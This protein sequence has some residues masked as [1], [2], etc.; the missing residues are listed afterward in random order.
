MNQHMYTHSTLQTIQEAQNIAIKHNHTTL[1]PEHIMHALL[2]DQEGLVPTILH[3]NTIDIPNLQSKTQSLLKNLPQAT[4]SPTQISLSRESQNVLQQ[5]E[6]NID[7]FWDKY[8]T[9]EHVCIALITLVPS[10][11]ELFQECNIDRKKLID[12]IQFVRQW[13]T[14]HTA[15]SDIILDALGKY[16]KDITSLAE[17]GK[18]DPIIGRHTE[19]RRTM[20]ILSRR[21]K[22]N[23]V[24]VGDPW[25]WKTAIVEG[26]A[27][28]INKKEVPD[29]LQN[30][31]LI[32]LDLSSMLA[33]AKYRWDFEERLKAVLH[34]V[35][36][37]NDRI[38]LF[39]DEL[40]TIVWAWKTEWSADMGN[41]LKP[42]LARGHIRVIGATTI[43]EYRQ[44]I[45][46]DAALE[47]R[48]QPVMVTEPTREEAITILRGIKDRYETHH[49][50]RIT[51]EAVVAAVDL[52]IKYIN[53]RRLPDKAIDLIDEAWAS[54]KINI[55]SLPEHLQNIEK[56][57]KELQ[58]EKEAIKR[59]AW[60]KNTDRI[61]TIEKNIAE[62]HEQY[63]INKTKREKDK[64]LLTRGKE[65]KEEIQNLEH[66]ANIAEKQTDWTQVAEI[67]HGKIP[68]LREELENI[69]TQLEKAKEEGS[70]VINDHVEPENIASIISR[71]TGIPTT[72]LIQTETEK[73]IRLEE[74]LSKKVIGQD[75]AVHTVAN[76]IRR[77]K[78]WLQ[79]PQRPLAS[80][81]F[82]GP[83][84]VGKTELAKALAAFLFNDSS[85]MIRLDM[86]EY[87]ERHTIAKL[88]WSP[89]GYI[90]Y[91]QGWQLTEAVRRKPYSVILFDEVEKAHPDIFNTLLQL[92]D[93][94]H[95][96][97][98]TW[99][100][101]N[102]KHTIIIMTS[103]LAQE[104]KDTNLMMQELQTYFRP[105][106]LNR[107]D[108]IIRFNPL[109]K[110]IILAIL[111]IH[112]KDLI[113]Q[114]KKDKHIHI[115]VHNAAKEYLADIG[116]NSQFGARP[117]QRA[118]QNNLLDKLAMGLLDGTI[119]AWDKIS[120]DVEE[121]IL[122]L[123][124][125]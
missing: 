48:F 81:L 45:E 41:M 2:Q 91:E 40:H 76:A 51:D 123:Q 35:E 50:I 120:V 72:K 101:V 121:G 29:I 103:N 84:W 109:S 57:I 46:K 47:R 71:R 26:L 110:D 19:I 6:K 25:V 22:N 30:K 49:G 63:T 113:Q 99:R 122:M 117:L 78:A 66:Q 95:L 112:I 85:A 80:F 56:E 87:A 105:E 73:L 16:G 86:S 32:E 36:A 24:L 114:L 65:I 69:T 116:Y 79:D 62:L 115:H 106:F 70:L 5:A 33:W 60:T 119:Q 4:T 97:D 10:L 83:T 28:L 1:T 61:T 9:T 44:H 3:A 104:A 111:D 54:V 21:T 38:I 124:K 17:Q 107:L 118:L 52:S 82:L 64:T 13:R 59:D 68:K 31:R 18:I 98:S 11:K 92:L 15:E 90:W 93:D 27:I 74:H 125:A 108:D 100:T 55:S 67:I 7:L 94:G 102:F 14:V 39:I 96:T 77:A 23:P 42:A 37:S 88:I 8:V 75:H 89:P 12:M 34:E 53:D 20:Q 58:V 43:N